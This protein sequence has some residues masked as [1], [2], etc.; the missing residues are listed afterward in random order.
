M[1]RINL[2]PP[3]ILERRKSE[4]RF[5]WVILAALMVAVVLAGVWVFA[6]LRLQGKQDELAAVQQEV[7]T[8]NTRAAQLAI[9]E[10]RA[11]E[12]EARRAT[13]DLALSSRRNWAKLL[14]ELSLVLPADVWVDT[15]SA[16]EE[17]GLQIDGYAVDAPTDAPDLGHKTMAKMLVRLAD[18]D[19]LFNVWLTSSTKAEF[20]AQPVLEYTVTAEVSE[21][22][23][24]SDTP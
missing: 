2:L 7:Q 10:E 6:F 13:A 23:T 24:G 9:F 21:P 12:L 14:S 1:M 8:T 19:Q 17:S 22:T 16:S 5:G 20:E 3:E 15:L 4:R 11:G 18:L